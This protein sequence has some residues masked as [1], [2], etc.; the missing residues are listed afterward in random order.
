[1]SNEDGTGVFIPLT[2]R[3]TRSLYIGRRKSHKKAKM[4]RQR[5]ATT[6]CSTCPQNPPK[7][8]EHLQQDANV[9]SSPSS[10]SSHESGPVRSSST[11]SLSYSNNEADAADMVFGGNSTCNG[12][13][14]WAGQQHMGT[15]APMQQLPR[16][17]TESA[18]P[19]HYLAP[20]MVAHSQQEA[21]TLCPVYCCCRRSHAYY[22]PTYSWAPGW[23]VGCVGVPFSQVPGQEMPSGGDRAT[24]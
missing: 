24:G 11:S 21:V 2:S 13:Y 1:M 9:R 12:Y 10:Q 17:P 4:A 20:V 15:W 18:V 6:P 22:Y 23:P 8:L 14:A 16:A 3:D 19:A 7:H 5:V